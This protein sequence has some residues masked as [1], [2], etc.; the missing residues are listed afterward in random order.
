VPVVLIVD[1]DRSVIDTFSR[2][3]RLEGYGVV[4]ALNTGDALR[5]F[6][7]AR[8]DAILLDLHMPL[9]DGITLLRR[10]RTRGVGRPTPVAVITGDYFPSETLQKELRELHVHLYFKPLWIADLVLIVQKLVEE[11]ST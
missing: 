5:A 4:S 8:P 6:E 11:S 9:Q 7:S 10:V 1:D 3:L 2:M